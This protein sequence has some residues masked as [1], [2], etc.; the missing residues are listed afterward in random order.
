MGPE[1]LGVVPR[2]LPP[3]GDG[4]VFPGDEGQ[5]YR[6]NPGEGF[7]EAYRALNN[8]KH[9]ATTF[10][11]PIV[12][13]I[14]YPDTTALQAVEQ[15]VLQPWTAPTVKTVRGR[16][17]TKGRRRFTLTLSTPLDAARGRSQAAQGRSVRA[18]P[19]GRRRPHETRVRPLGGKDR[20][21]PLLHDLRAA[22]ASPRRYAVGN[23]GSLFPRGHAALNRSASPTTAGETR[24][25]LEAGGSAVLP[26]H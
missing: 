16:F 21:D 1:A 26:R 6:Q 24:S 18:R 22:V 15:D 9:G 5:H 25:R 19:P 7:A 10:D 3:R 4:T 2:R 13:T 17:T 23:G 8:S 11:W 12:D 14:F 20:E